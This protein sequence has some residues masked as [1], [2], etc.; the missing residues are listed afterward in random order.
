MFA[1]LSIVMTTSGCFRSM[2]GKQ[3]LPNRVSDTPNHGQ[4]DSSVGFPE[5]VEKLYIKDIK[6]LY[7]ERAYRFAIEKE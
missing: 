4:F 6:A 2:V 5:G 7:K 1:S 3:T